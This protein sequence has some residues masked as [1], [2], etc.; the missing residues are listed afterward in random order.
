MTL[1]KGVQIRNRDLTQGGDE[2]NQKILKMFY[3]PLYKILLVRRG[4]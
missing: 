4:Y 3:F 2:K 1:I